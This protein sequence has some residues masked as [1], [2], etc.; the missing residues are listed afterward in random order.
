MNKKKYFVFHY[1]QFAGQ[2]MV[3]KKVNEEK[4]EYCKRTCFYKIKLLKSFMEL[5][6]HQNETQK[7][8]KTSLKR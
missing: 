5:N 4:Y 7:N 1:K 8:L 3:R 2:E 6:Q